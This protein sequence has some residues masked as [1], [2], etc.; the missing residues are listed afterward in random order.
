MSTEIVIKTQVRDIIKRETKYSQG[1]EG[2]FAWF[3]GS[4]ESLFV[5]TEPPD[6]KIGDEMEIVIR[7]ARQRT[8]AHEP[9]NK[10]QT[11]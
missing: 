11:K 2:Y 10:I 9:D 8:T 6:F 4:S 3:E 7:K 5:G 1:Q